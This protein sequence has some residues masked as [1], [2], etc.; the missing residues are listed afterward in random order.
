MNQPETALELAKLAAM[1]DPELAK[2]EANEAITRAAE[3]WHAGLE[4]AALSLHLI[5]S[6]DRDI[7]AQ[8][9]A[10][11]FLHCWLKRDDDS[12]RRWLLEIEAPQHIRAR[13]YRAH[14][15]AIRRH[16]LRVVERRAEDCFALTHET[17]KKYIALERD[18]MRK[19]AA[20]RRA[21]KKKQRDLQ[22]PR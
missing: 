2:Q 22:R 21:K 7:Q 14:L 20:D 15:G 12:F 4:L 3:L 19:K 1:L 9:S 11:D 13:G 5:E 18:R 8:R 6:W 16:G 17:A 10:R